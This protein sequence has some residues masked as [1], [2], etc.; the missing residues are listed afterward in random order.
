MNNKELKTPNK[1]TVEVN[2]VQEIKCTAIGC[3]EVSIG[4]YSG[5]G[6]YACAYHMRKWDDEFD[7]EYK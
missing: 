4:D 1:D 5:H 7:E 2:R 6:D 3:T